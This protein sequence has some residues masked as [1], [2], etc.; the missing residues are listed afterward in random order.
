MD[1]ADMFKVSLHAGQAGREFYAAKWQ[2]DPGFLI[3][4][5]IESLRKAADACGYVMIKRE[6]VKT[7]VEALDEAATYFDNLADGDN[8]GPNNEARLYE[9]CIRAWNNLPKEVK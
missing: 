4:T 7:I 5:G 2:D 6:Y 1:K 9:L 8:D 3:E